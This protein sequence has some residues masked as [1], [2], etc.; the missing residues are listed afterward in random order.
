MWAPWTMDRRL[1]A[2]ETVRAAARAL[3]RAGRRM[4]IGRA[5]MPM[6]TRSSTRVKPRIVRL[7]LP[8]MSH[9]S[10]SDQKRSVTSALAA[11][12]FV[13]GLGGR[14]LAAGVGL[15]VVADD[16]AVA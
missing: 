4:A 6:T 7:G 13:F 5:M 10:F 8:F 15:G 2:Q 14:G 16:Q 3:P 9:P 11:P 12:G 1:A